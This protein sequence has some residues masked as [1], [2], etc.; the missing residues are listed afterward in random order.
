MT[1]SQTV[2]YFI[3]PLTALGLSC[4]V[5]VPPLPQS[6]S[7]WQNCKEKIDCMEL[8]GFCNSPFVLNKKYE[9][10]YRA[11]K[12]KNEPS[13]NCSEHSFQD[14][15]EVYEVTCLKSQCQIKPLD[16]DKAPRSTRS[17]PKN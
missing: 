6:P 14:W 2:K 12:R 5:T 16:N 9:D 17:F 3:G 4:C 15:P 10:S 1:L 7:L 13:L 8:R 11:F